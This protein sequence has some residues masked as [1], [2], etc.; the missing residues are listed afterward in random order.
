MTSI[1]FV[2]KNK[3]RKNLNILEYQCNKTHIHFDNL[4]IFGNKKFQ[5]N[6]RKYS[7]RLKNY[8]QKN[9]YFIKPNWRYYCKIT[10]IL[11]HPLETHK[12]RKYWVKNRAVLDSERKACSQINWLDSLWILDIL[13]DEWQEPGMTSHSISCSKYKYDSIKKMFYDKHKNS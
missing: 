7:F 10:P 1:V 4:S 5:F 11:V 13:K 2:K 6:Y 3:K 9:C 12:K 8:K